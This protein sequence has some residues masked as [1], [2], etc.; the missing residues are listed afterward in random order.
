MTG[1]VM[2]VLVFNEIMAPFAYLGVVF[3]LAAC[4]LIAVMDSKKK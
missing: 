4:I 2:G 3:V 1:V